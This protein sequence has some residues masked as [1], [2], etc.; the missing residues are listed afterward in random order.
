M[1]FGGGSS[2]DEVEVAKINKEAEAEAREEERLAAEQALRNDEAVKA[3]KS[4]D[5]L[6]ALTSA[7]T[8]AITGAEDYFSLQG[9]DPANYLAD[10]TRAA[11]NKRLTVPKGA[12]DPF[13]YF[14]NFNEQVFDNLS[15][16]NRARA[17]KDLNKITSSGFE[18]DLLSDTVDDSIIKSLFEDKKSDALKSLETLFA[19]DVLT[20]SG[21]TAAVDDITEQS[22]GAK[23]IL[24]QIGN[25]LIEKGRG[26]LRSISADARDNVANL[27]L[28][29]LFQTSDL[30]TNLNDSVSKFLESLSGELKAS[31]SDDIF[32]LSKAF[33]A[34]GFSQGA[35]NTKY[36]PDASA[37]L[38]KNLFNDED[39]D[40]E[41]KEETNILAN[42][43]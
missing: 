6:A 5:A 32:D 9:L 12:E 36:D 13:T 15:D 21:Y 43:F 29:D 27:E 19:R 10:I 1:C 17:E 14:T 42:A 41:D 4:Q 38:F 3:Q 31:V 28:G 22:Y 35:Q 26:D 37:G 24:E 16:A 33:T 8:N 25:S 40:D 39:D 11:D 20:K 2:G 7:Y 18:K 23:S 34:G 30:Q